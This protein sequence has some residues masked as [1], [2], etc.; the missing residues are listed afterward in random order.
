[1]RS[2]RLTAAL[3]L[4]AL[5]SACG[6]IPPRQDPD[7]V[8][9]RYAA[10]AGAPLDRI[11]WLGR[12]D[13]W[14]SLG[15]NQVLVFTTPSDA[16]LIDVAPPCTD[17]PFVQHIALTS[18]GSTVSAR[19]DSVIVN[20]WRCQIAQIRRVD[21]ARMRADLRQEAEA[22]KAAKPAS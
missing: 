9:A 4:I 6:G 8:R 3:A 5:L 15:N 13:S 11:T 1:M 12:F 7:A 10:Y 22:A 21:Y 20:K 14:E 2:H 18:T 16:Y 17:L 19:L